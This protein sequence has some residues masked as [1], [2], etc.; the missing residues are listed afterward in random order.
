MSNEYNCLDDVPISVRRSIQQGSP[1]PSHYSL[2]SNSPVP[3]QVMS[4]NAHTTQAAASPQPGSINPGMDHI[5]F[6][7]MQQIAVPAHL[8]Q[9]LRENITFD[10][11]AVEDI[12]AAIIEI[13][14]RVAS[15]TAL[16]GEAVQSLDSG[17][18]ML[19]AGCQ[20]ME[21]HLSQV[22]Q[23]LH[24]QRDAVERNKQQQDADIRQMRESL[25]NFQ[26][27]QERKR[28]A[29][30]DANVQREAMLNAKLE[31]LEARVHQ[32]ERS[33]EGLTNAL[34]EQQGRLNVQEAILYAP[35]SEGSAEEPSLGPAV[36][37]LSE[38]VE[39]ELSKLAGE[40]QSLS[41][42]H[43]AQA[44]EETSGDA[45][46]AE[47]AQ[48]R[49]M[50]EQVCDRLCDLE[51]RQDTMHG[52]VPTRQVPGVQA[53]QGVTQVFE[54][55]PEPVEGVP[56]SGDTFPDLWASWHE[57]EK[58]SRELPTL[59]NPPALAPHLSKSARDGAGE[60]QQQ[61]LDPLQPLPPGLCHPSASAH[62]NPRD[63]GGMKVQWKV[64]GDMPEFNL[65]AHT[66][67]E[68]G[69]FFSTWKRQ[70]C[71]VAG[72]A[73]IRFQEYVEKCFRDA[74]TRYQQNARNEHPADLAGYHVFP[75]DY[76]GRF[77]VQLLKIL[78]ERIKTPA[79][80]LSMNAA[81]HP[82][83]ILE[84]LVAQ[85]QP[86]GQEE[87][88]SLTRFVRSLDPVNSAT[89][90]IS[91][92]RRWRLARSRV[93]TL[94]LPAAAPFEMLKGLYAL[95]NRL[96][97][98]HDALRTRLSICKLDTAVQL[99]TDRGVEIV[100]E[101]IE[102]ELR[103]IAADETTKSNAAG[104]GDL[105]VANKGLTKGNDKGKGK[106]SEKGDKKKQVCPFL[107]K[108]GGC[109]FGDRCFYKHPQNPLNPPNPPNPKA[110]PVSKP[111]P[112]KQRKCVF[113][114]RKSGCKLGD[115][116]PYK[117]EGPSGSSKAEA[118][119]ALVGAGQDSTAT[120][121]KAAPKPKASAK[122]SSISIVCM[123]LNPGSPASQPDGNESDESAS[124]SPLSAGH[125]TLY[126]SDPT[127]SVGSNAEE[128]SGSEDQIFVPADEEQG[129][130]EHAFENAPAP[131]APTVC[132]PP[133]RAT[134]E[135]PTGSSQERAHP[136][137]SHVCNSAEGLGE[138]LL[139]TGANEIV[140]SQPHYPSRAMP[141]SLSLA[142]G[143]VIQA[144]RSRNGE[145]IVIGQG[146]G[147][148][149]C[150][151][152]RLIQIG[153]KFIW[154]MPSG[155]ILILPEALNGETIKLRLHNGLPYMGYPV[156]KR[157]RPLMSQWWKSS[158]ACNKVSTGTAEKGSTIHQNDT[159]G[160]AKYLLAVDFD[161]VQ[162]LCA[163]IDTRTSA[164]DLN[165]KTLGK[166]GLDLNP[167]LQAKGYNRKREIEAEE[168]WASELLAKG[169]EHLT[170]DSV[171]A[172]IRRCSLQPQVKR[173][174]CVDGNDHLIRT[175]MFGLW[176]H[177]S[178]NG[179]SCLLGERP[180]LTRVLV[181]FIRKI[182][183]NLSFTTLIIND[184]LTFLPHKDA[185]NL[186]ASKNGLVCLNS[187]RDCHGGGLWVQDADG[188]ELRQ[189]RP[190]VHKHGRVHD[191]RRRPL[192]FDGR[193]LHG[194]ES[195]EGDRVTISAYSGNGV[196]SLSSEDRA[197]LL[198]CGFPLPPEALAKGVD[199]I[200]RPE[201]L[202]F[203]QPSD[204]SNPRIGPVCQAEGEATAEAAAAE[205]TSMNIKPRTN[206]PPEIS[207]H[208]EFWDEVCS[209]QA[210]EG[211]GVQDRGD[212]SDV[213][214]VCL[215]EVV[216][217]SDGES[218][219][220]LDP[221][222]L[223]RQR[224]LE[225]L[226]L[227]GPVADPVKKPDHTLE[228]FQTRG[229]RRPHRRV[230]AEELSTGVLSLDLAG[231]YKPGY[232][233]VQYMLVAALRLVDGRV[234]QFTRGLRRRL[235]DGV[236][237]AVQ[238]ILSE[239]S[240]LAG[241]K[242]SI[243]RIHSDRAREFL[244]EKLVDGINKL[245]VFKTTT[246]GYDPQAN[247]LA[248]RSVGQLKEAALGFMIK[249]RVKAYYWSLMM[250]EAARRNRDAVLGIK[251]QGKLPAPGDAV[252]VSIHNAQPFEPKAEHGVYL[253]QARTVPHGALV[254][255]QRNGSPQVI[256][257]RLPALLEEPSETWRTHTTPLGDLIWVSSTGKVRDAETIRDLGVDLGLLTVEERALGCSD[258]DG[259]PFVGKVACEESGTGN[260]PI[261][262]TPHLDKDPGKGYVVLSHAME[263][264][265]LQTEEGS[266]R[267]TVTEHEDAG[268]FF[269]ES[270][271]EWEFQKW[272]DGLNQELCSM[273]QKGVLEEVV[274]DQSMK[275]V[276]SKLVLTKKP[277]EDSEI[278]ISDQMGASEVADLV[279]KS[280]RAR[281]RLVACGNY[282]QGTKAGDPDNY[283]SNP[284]QEMFRTLVSMMTRWST[285]WTCMVLDISCAFLNAPL[286]NDPNAKPVHILPPS[287]LYK[288]GLI[289]KGTVWRAKRA[290][291]GLRR[292]PKQWEI[293]RNNELTNT[294]LEPG[295]NHCLGQLTLHELESGAWAVRQADG[296]I[297][298][299]LIMY[300]D[301]AFIVGSIELCTRIKARLRALW[302]LKIQGLLHND[303]LELRAGD[304]VDLDGEQVQ[305]KSEV[306]YLG[307]Q[308]GRNQSGIFLH[309][310]A[311]IQSEIRK[312]SWLHLGSAETLPELDEGKWVPQEK[313]LEYKEALKDCQSEIGSLQWLCQRT[314]PDLC[315][316][317]GSLASLMTVDPKRVLD[318]TKRVWRYVKGTL[319]YKLHYSFNTTWE[320][321]LLC[322]GD[323]SWAPGAS[324]SRTG[325]W[326]CWGEHPLAWKSSRQ[327]VTA[328]SA[329]EAEVDAA[330]STT[331]IGVTIKRLLSQLLQYQI[332]TDL[333][334]DNAACVVHLVREDGA[335]LT[336]RTRTVGIRCS[337][338]R[339]QAVNEGLD[340]H[341]MPGNELPADALTKVLRRGPLEVARCKL[342]LHV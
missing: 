170:Y 84:E 181:A 240:A 46:R 219:V 146:H 141:L 132:P 26:A 167:R 58:S 322:Y 192:T 217:I 79:M 179:L 288:L 334:S 9:Q 150:G 155:P 299:L 60:K 65:T 281:V 102:R 105:L 31:S 45:L 249:G 25:E 173:R 6:R 316:V 112:Q 162:E 297:A 317:T 137:A 168:L 222:D 81:L 280:W 232:D 166:G 312:R 332:E 277:M 293:E 335:F 110:A 14:D 270:T 53:T 73:C 268:V 338:I 204:N 41:I 3:E 315:A 147:H 324:K 76:A 213:F 208:K 12:R 252:A 13:N 67:W 164:E 233:R 200:D 336:V 196:Q 44:S 203:P 290:I 323:A 61:L 250:E 237:A 98:K 16:L 199:S 314:R 303:H 56:H 248:E 80:E 220:S 127:P 37:A 48:V 20:T 214:Q 283:S 210:R 106:G 266:H 182:M 7:S 109:T 223:E 145:V 22:T 4:P 158:C 148:T 128:E 151:V 184:N 125:V 23:L 321:K 197:S 311:W 330:A 120:Q 205:H 263:Q 326:I 296:T 235:W 160:E 265:M 254:L 319:N 259:V 75:E 123:V 291:Y 119:K 117:H 269:R 111:E 52:Q 227:E 97:K 89:E 209:A 257:T 47:F 258:P 15:R 90:A 284:G 247:G 238:G 267:I 178:M 50:V 85:V 337:Y 294:V 246:A 130:F 86:G 207:S 82:T 189:I 152:N 302:D 300:V 2:V 122:A 143:Q 1:N 211:H 328:W 278:C 251:T 201:P 318:L 191:I 339:D 169:L 188:S 91:T 116:C 124:L 29:A 329:F 114:K 28:V 71:T 286:D 57:E 276:P 225:R 186:A 241:E 83:S 230:K 103:L 92:L 310:G 149:I 108:P 69:M 228:G 32:L 68:L 245:G 215:G 307:M 187:S 107:S 185:R 140:T 18:T 341:H 301:D 172:L 42:T 331:Q 87:Q 95:V 183:P 11:G 224:E 340:V 234:L 256:L 242:P 121:A 30:L 202:G 313:T 275:P 218:C 212:Y 51:P 62:E 35:K 285:T 261:N 308:V 135:V 271:P 239:A 292:S 104:P 64:L 206:G 96:E 287:I 59:T 226:E 144:K 295:D 193:V 49:D 159:Q 40:L 129:D 231:P 24:V 100:L 39:R 21:R 99:G 33:N 325:V 274:Q 72:T 190:N 63:S 17:M 94:G 195:W 333:F 156:F 38:K 260:P 74:E 139:D 163:R 327:S 70:V 134:S 175:W 180:Q 138:V 19:Q 5:L 244:A 273:Q 342:G 306:T 154:S 78:P 194:T 216:D 304:Q 115:A 282:E 118:P 171:L 243:V 161:V 131:K 221:E 309:Q 10:L 272:L 320:D 8:V 177:G 43:S 126:S 236:F 198:K 153:C 253:A 262:G 305:V 255:V 36:Q 165:P 279:S 27:E 66:P 133:S 88:A 142:D 54:M 34:R 93:Q 229:L 55:S 136:K 298:G 176:T 101:Q 113:H 174:A 157:L 264:D 77:V 289:P